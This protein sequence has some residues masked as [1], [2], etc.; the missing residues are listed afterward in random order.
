[1]DYNK[2]VN[3]I[4]KYFK[5]HEKIEED[6][7]IGI[8][9]EHFVIDKDTLQTISYY[10]KD[11]VEETLKELETQGWEG[12]YE[13]DY[14]LGL[15]SNNKVI[16]LEPGSQLEF[17]V[18][19]QKNIEEIER[20][21]LGFL[22]Q[23]IPILERKN[24][25]LIAIGYHP[26]TRINDIK[27][28]PKKRYSYMFEYFKNKGI[29]AHNMMKGTASLQVAVDY[30]SEEDYIKKFKIA[31]ALSPVLYAMFDN[32]FYFEGQRWNKHNLRAYIW[33]NCDR[34][35]S[36]IV[37]GVF[38]KDFGYEKYAEYILN[39]PPIFMDDGKNMYSTGNKL[40]KEIFN[41][42]N[43]SI[44]ELEHMLTM[45]FPDVRTK[46]Y[47]EIRMIDAIP[48]PLNLA[49]VALLKGILYDKNNLNKVYEHIK[50]LTIDDVEKTKISIFNK[51]IDGKFK[52][53]SIYEIGKMIME[54]AKAGLNSDELRYILPLEKMIMEKKNPYEIIR[55]KEYLGK[56][57]SINWCILNHL[58]E[59]NEHGRVEFN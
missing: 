46:K 16:T 33:E 36:G 24:Q 26:E 35:R 57:E 32:G 4:V 11:G 20:E 12:S 8:E 59:G 37:K 56:K 17:S 27:I 31:N 45:F 29:H 50:D 51:G 48:Y 53:K 21:Y 47:I 58:V 2:Q 15:N 13:G 44:E 40:V 18:K 23:I 19:P 38:D 54:I 52:D 9:F 30:K 41:P 42:E 1:M 14:L 6:F 22:Q 39:G 25:G 49:A 5:S 55:E 10:G 7:K 28:L 3:E 34:D 43:Y